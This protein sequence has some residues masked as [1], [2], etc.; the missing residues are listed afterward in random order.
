MKESGK[1]EF[2][3]DD[4]VKGMKFPE[5]TYTLTPEIL[6]SYLEGVDD[7]NPLYL[8]EEYAGRYPELEKCYY[9]KISITDTGNGIP[10]K[11]KDKIF[12]PF[13]TTKPKEKG[14]GLGL[15]MVYNILKNHNGFIN[16]YSEYS[17]Y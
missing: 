9:I 3:Y 2:L 17:L 11:I 7:F 12:E 15:A 8:D 4:M 6:E 10:K 14:T 1:K 16:V 13:F 5:I